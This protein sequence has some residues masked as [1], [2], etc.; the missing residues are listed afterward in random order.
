MAP[1]SSSC[2]RACELW[3]PYIWAIPSPT[4]VTIPTSA[5]RTGTSNSRR[6]C[7]IRLLI[8]S[9]RMPTDSSL[10]PSQLLSKPLELGRHAAVDEP[11]A[12]LNA[13][14]RDQS[15]LHLVAELDLASQ[16]PRQRPLVPPT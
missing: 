3:R 2:S 6:R 14:P 15:R 9:D 4:S 16:P 12:D 8:S 7:L 5:L 10:L 13:G 1:L 11:I